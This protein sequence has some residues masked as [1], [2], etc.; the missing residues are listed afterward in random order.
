MSKVRKE[1]LH[2]LDPGA[3]SGILSAAIIDTL[4]KTT[5]LRQIEL[6]LYENN[7]DIIPLLRSNLIY[8]QKVAEQN[9]IILNYNIIEENFIV[10]NHFVWTGLIPSEKY[11]ILLFGDYILCEPF[12]IIG[13]IF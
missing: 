7:L 6:D 8:V 13:E 12:I 10:T 2:I 1:T 3:G 4:L 5:G 9:N 11:D